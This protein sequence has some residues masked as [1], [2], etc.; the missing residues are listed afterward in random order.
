MLNISQHFFGRNGV[1]GWSCKTSTLQTN[2][3]VIE[4]IETQLIPHI[5]LFHA[6]KESR[7]TEIGL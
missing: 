5:A 2:C 1:F 4:N 7:T 6:I 3:F